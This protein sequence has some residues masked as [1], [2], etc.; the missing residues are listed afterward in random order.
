MTMMSLLIFLA[1]SLPPLVLLYLRER[2]HQE[3]EEQWT[4]IFCVKSLE[5]PQR[6]MDG[7]V[8]EEKAQKPLDTRKRLSFPLP[9]ADSVK[10]VYR[11]LHRQ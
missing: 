6:S 10:D 5:I 9:I 1:G 7:N 4:R 2:M 11:K 8:K 3:R